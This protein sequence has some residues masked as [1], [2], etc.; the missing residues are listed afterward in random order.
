M[1]VL[2]TKHPDACPPLAACLD[3]YPE[4]PPEMVPVDITDDVVSAVAGRL[5]GGAGPGGTDSVSLQH[6]LLRFRAAIGER[7]AKADCCGVR[8]MAKQWAASM[9]R[10][11]SHDFRPVD[12][13]GQEFRNQTGWDRQDLVPPTGEVPPAGDGAGG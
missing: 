3:A 4:N 5:L 1:E 10:L 9:G 13:A 12:R 2:R 6:W 7:Q 11:S 8:G